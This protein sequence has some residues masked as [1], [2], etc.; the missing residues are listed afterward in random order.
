M[1]LYVFELSLFLYLYIRPLQP[2]LPPEV[3]A[4]VG[5]MYLRF[6]SFIVKSEKIALCSFALLGTI[7]QA[8]L[9]GYPGIKS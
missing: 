1:K 2:V 8:E 7:F 6:R 3:K 9:S 4:Q 5:P